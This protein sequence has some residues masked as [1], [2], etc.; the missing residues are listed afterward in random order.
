MVPGY[1][2]TNV[3]GVPLIMKPKKILFGLRQS[4]KN[5]FSTMDRHL[6][7]NRV[8]TSQIGPVRLHLRGRNGSVI[9]TLYVDGVLLQG[10]NKQLLGKLKKQLMDRFEMTG[11]GDVSRVLGMNVTRDREEGNITI[12]QKDY[13]GTIVQRYGMRGCNPAYTP[14]VGPELSLDQPEKNLLNEKASG[15]TNQSQMR[16]CTLRISATTASSTPSSS[17]RG[18][19][20]AI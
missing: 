8:S 1:E 18:Q 13:T 12:N 2:R 16:L 19:C 3:S 17:W 10:A 4:S 6:G 11:M 20:R 15:D 7:K 14:E 9:L 5:W